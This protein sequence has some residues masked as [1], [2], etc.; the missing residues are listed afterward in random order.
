MTTNNSVKW[1]SNSVFSGSDTEWCL[2]R[3]DSEGCLFHIGYYESHYFITNHRY[4]QFYISK[5]EFERLFNN[6]E[7]VLMEI[8]L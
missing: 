2:V 3:G 4:E 5:E 6:P 7:N 1:L 8:L